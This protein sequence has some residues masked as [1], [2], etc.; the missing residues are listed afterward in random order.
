LLNYFNDFTQISAKFEAK[1]NEVQDGRPAEFE[2]VNTAKTAISY[3]A[4]LINFVNKEYGLFH[5]LFNELAHY[6]ERAKAKITP[7]IAAIPEENQTAEVPKLTEST[8]VDMFNHNLELDARL[9]LIHYIAVHSDTKLTKQDL[10]V[11][12]E[13]LISNNPMFGD[14]QIVYKW[15]RGII[16]D[17]L[18]NR[19][20]LIDESE[21]I[22]FFKAKIADENDDSQFKNLSIEGY[23]C[24]QSFF[25]LINMKNRKLY[26]LG[27]EEQ[28]VPIKKGN[29][30]PGTQAEFAQNATQSFTSYSNTTGA[31]TK[32]YSFNK[33]TTSTSTS[34]T[35]AAAASGAT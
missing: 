26:I 34:T 6:M 19:L 28:D 15:L 16:D 2:E 3:K 1:Q 22:E 33:N 4:D 29:T 32:S 18:K 11:I 17:C 12:W 13:E 10:L 24:I 30:A 8:V 7:L 27:D 20:G 31:Q 23:Y 5:L 21:L 14:H 9:K 25:L 35:L